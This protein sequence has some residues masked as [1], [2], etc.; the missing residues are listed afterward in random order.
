MIEQQTDNGIM[1]IIQTYVPTT[2]KED[3]EVEEFYAGLDIVLA[4]I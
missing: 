1:S 4:S 2:D 3:E